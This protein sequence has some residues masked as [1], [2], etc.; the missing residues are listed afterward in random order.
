M[1]KLFVFAIGGTGERVMRSLTMVLASGAPAFDNYDVYP[2]IIDYDQNNADKDRTVRLLQ[3]Y[4]GVHDAA[5]TRHSENTITKGQANQFFAAKLRNLNGLTNY[6][7]P[8]SPAKPNEKFKE[9]IG[10]DNLVGDNLATKAFL[11]TL[12]DNSN[13]PDTELNLDMTVGFKGNPNIGS[14]VFHSIGETPE[15]AAFKSLF[16]PGAGD[17][18]VVIGSLFGGTGASGIPEIVKAIDAMKVN[19]RIATILVLP[20]FSPMVVKGGAIQSS[21][22]DSKTKAA[23]SFYEDSKINGKIDK[24]YYVGDPYRTTIPYS[25]G[26]LKQ[27][28]NANMVE[29]IAAMMIEHYVSGKDASGKYFKYSLDIDIALGSKK[30]QRLFVPDFDMNSIDFIF[31]HL[32]TLSIGLK[33]IRDEIVGRSSEAR[34]QGFW[35]I[36]DLDHVVASSSYVIT[37]SDSPLKKLCKQLDDYYNEYAEW[38]KELDF[39]GVGDSIPANSHRLAICDMKRPYSDIMQKGAVKKDDNQTILKKALAWIS[40]KKSIDSDFVL[41]RMNNNFNSHL[42][43]GKTDLKADHEPEWAFADSLHAASKDVFNELNNK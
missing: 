36:L 31:N 37:D 42:M 22:F 4:A 3:N 14:V 12:Y 15:F 25:D 1:P 23:L 10:L 2:I 38:M 24:I 27:K 16:Q 21:R 7:F 39:E 41:T 19:A 13:N 32:A 33:C 9:Y 18:V 17:K 5:F 30:N 11:E 8:F 6:T 35:K 34:N 29:L 28:N 43:D 20:Y 26:G 40:S